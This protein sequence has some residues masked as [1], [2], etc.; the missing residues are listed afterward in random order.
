MDAFKFIIPLTALLSL[1]ILAINNKV[2]VGNFNFKELFKWIIVILVIL[3]V[4][5]GASNYYMIKDIYVKDLMTRSV[6]SITTG[7][8]SNISFIFFTIGE[9]YGWRYYLQ[10]KLQ[11]I[12]DKRV[13]VLLTGLIWGLFHVP[14]YGFLFYSGLEGVYA[15]VNIVISCIAMGVFLGLI[16]MRSNSVIMVSRCPRPGAP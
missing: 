7:L 8:I 3:N 13:G 10:A 6:F 4:L 11:K 9:E 15:C 12:S 5:M 16:Y 1:Y 2:L 14:L